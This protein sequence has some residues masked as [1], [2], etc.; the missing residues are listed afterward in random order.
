VV[1]VHLAVQQVNPR[2]LHGLDDGVHLGP[3]TAFGKVGNTFD[4][5]GH[6]RGRI[7]EIGSLSH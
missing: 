5:R 2:Q 6:N 1:G 3:V 7:K 4:K